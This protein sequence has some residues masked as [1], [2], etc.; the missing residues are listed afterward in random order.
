V[1][2]EALWSV[3]ALD[4]ELGYLLEPKSAPPGWQAGEQILARFWRFDGRQS[5]SRD[6]ADAWLARHAGTAGVGGLQPAIAE[7]AYN[8]TVARI[9]SLIF[10]GD[11]Y[12]VNFTFPLEFEWFGSPLALYARLRER[13]PV[14]YG[15]FV[16][17][18]RQGLVS[19]SP[20]LFIE[21]QG[22][23]LV[24]RPM[25]GTA[26]RSVPQ[27]QLLASAKDRAENLMIVDLLRN[28]LGR[29]ADN[30]S[31]VV[32]RLFDIEDYPTVWQ[33]VS[34]ISA[35]VGKR[36]F[37]D[38]LHALF[39]CG[40]ITGAPKVRAMQ[41]VGELEGAE[42]GAY[43]GALGW[44]A[45]NGDFRLNVAIRT[46]ELGPDGRGKLGVGS[47]V[48]A[49]SDA[50]AEWAEC[51]L[52]AGFLRD[53][54]PGMLLIETLRR[55]DGV[56]PRLAGHLARLRRS[57]AWLGFVCDEQAV[58]ASLAE[59]PERGVWRVRMTLAKD[60]RV[61]V[62][63]FALGEE[64]AG[65]RH[66]RLATK[67]IDSAYP[68][69]R[70]KTTDRAVYD[71]ALAMLAGDPELFDM[72][73]L[74]ERGEVAEGARSTVFVERDGILLTPPLTSGALPGVLRAE[75]LAAGRAREAVLLPEDLSAG[76]WLGNALRGLMPVS[77][78]SI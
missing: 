50:A 78:R 17:D 23:R 53:C 27:E 32:E 18:A 40:S 51:Q 68:L 59:Q 35:R 6:E 67:A 70:H 47:G 75:L 52:K 12:Q 37:G 34:E 8:A 66:A 3:A 77:L 15:G 26:P 55:E 5:L 74:N 41:I 14:R 36:G 29:V 16:G 43:T 10:A 64:P 4:Y 58:K 44:L 60:G 21:R 76:F 19:L 69:R 25:K 63:S 24:T 13:Q 7:G 28:D 56:Y 65:L 20:E 71:A 73:F 46:L 72:V 48:V 54:D 22:E 39:P 45:P 42:R 38:I 11:C 33:M 62:T 49:D 57:A 9:K 61:E 2:G 31:V 1:Q 30:G